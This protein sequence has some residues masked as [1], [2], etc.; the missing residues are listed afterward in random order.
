[1]ADRRNVVLTG[2]MATGKTTVG[3][4]LAERLGY[5][6]VDTDTLVE[7]RHGPIP[8]IFAERGEGEFRRL[9]REVAVEVA[10]RTGQV[11]ST[12][13]RMLVDDTN[14]ATLSAT[15]DVVCLTAEV[16]TIVDRLRATGADSRPML[17]GHD[18]PSR[19]GHLLAE[20]QAAYARFR[21]VPTDRRSPAEIVDGIVRL[22]GAGRPD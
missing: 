15:G 21:Q 5:D 19:V 4:L 13:G 17:A 2:F 10:A 16:G 1:M 9:E 6:F 14:A 11:V 3:R 20:R 18:L 12:G 22:L 8:A 7:Q